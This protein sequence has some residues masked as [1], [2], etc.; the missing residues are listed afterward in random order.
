MNKN[1]AGSMPHP[2]IVLVAAAIGGA[3]GLL[4]LT[5]RYQPPVLPGSEGQ[6]VPEFTIW[7]FLIMVYTALL[8]ISAR[9]DVGVVY[10]PVPEAPSRGGRKKAAI[11]LL[12][13]LLTTVLLG[14]IVANTALYRMLPSP[15]YQDVLDPT[16]G[17]RMNFLYALTFLVLLP[18]VLGI[19]MIYLLG[20]HIHQQI[21]PGLSEEAN[22]A[23]GNDLLKLR[24]LL[25]YILL[26]CGI[27]LSMVPVNTAALRATILAAKPELE[28]YF[29]ITLVI[30]YGL[31]YSLLLILVYAPTH[32]KL[33]EVGRALRDQM[34]PID[35]LQ[36]QNLNEVIA[37]RKSLDEFLQTNIGIGENLKTGMITFTPL[38]TSLVLSLLGTKV[39]FLARG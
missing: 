30:I 14:V 27:I 29:P 32:M 6:I 22:F 17:M 12:L 18:G 39:S 20:E 4:L 37:R 33:V 10:P 24:G 28:P 35:G 16:H 26:V 36:L 5:W 19:V 31:F 23:L 2:L 1:L 8:A 13:L 21:G 7:L 3:F 9:A 11:S 15:N 34:C 38:V 25:Q